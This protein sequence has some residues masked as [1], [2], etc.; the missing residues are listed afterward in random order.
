MYINIVIKNIITRLW[1]AAADD[2]IL[3]NNMYHTPTNNI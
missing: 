2:V 3:T 1:E